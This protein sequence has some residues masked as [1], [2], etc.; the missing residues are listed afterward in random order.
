MGF[1]RFLSWVAFTLIFF[2]AISFPGSSLSHAQSPSARAGQEIACLERGHRDLGEAIRLLR[3]ARTQMQS[4]QG[5]ARAD[6]ERAV[7]SLEQRVERITT[8]LRAC[9]PE[10]TNR[11]IEEVRNP[12]GNDAR[13][14]EENAATE[15]IEENQ[16]MTPNI[17]V[18]LAEK[19]DG[20][21]RVDAQ[22]VRSAVRYAA[23]EFERCYSSLVGRGS[24]QSG[25]V[26]VT[27]TIDGDGR[28]RDTSSEGTT[29]GN[30]RFRRCIG[31]AARSIRSSRPAVGGTATY[32]YTLHFGN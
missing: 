27:F 24:L 19:V 1:S 11:P 15:T 12:T 23:S 17:R 18:I 21:G 10:R 14:G 20:H 6:A 2:S 26:F 13:V 16:Q 8:A 28:A 7:E 9:I 30:T 4:A 5:E 25:R 31:R 3:E 32:T 22:G 29:L